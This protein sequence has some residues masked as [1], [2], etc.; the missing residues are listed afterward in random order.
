MEVKVEI[1]IQTITAQYGA[2]EAGDILRTGAA[3]A[4]HLVDDCRCARYMTADQVGIDDTASQPLP[5][6][7]SRAAPAGKPK[8]KAVAKVQT[9]AQDETASKDKA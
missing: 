2:L 9:S 4:A 7:D 1:L 6:V 3:F 5:T 8:G